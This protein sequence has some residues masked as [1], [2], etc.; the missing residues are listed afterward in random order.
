MARKV[1][2]RFVFFA[3]WL[4]GHP[5]SGKPRGFHYKYKT[6]VAYANGARAQL[7]RWFGVNVAHLEVESNEFKN[8]KRALQT[9]LDDTTS[10][11]LPITPQHL[12]AFAA[13]L[14][15]RCTTSDFSPTEWT[16]IDISGSPDPEDPAHCPITLAD[17]QVKAMHLNACVFG[18][19][20]LLRISEFT[21]NSSSSLNCSKTSAL[22]PSK[23]SVSPW[24]L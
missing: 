8:T 18:W 5:A 21:S 17:C 7:S 19:S 16:H 13:R 22:R 9:I 14:D 4:A 23:W 12:L 11:R 20:L 6:V 15:M 3:L 1:D 2:L 24:R 10:P